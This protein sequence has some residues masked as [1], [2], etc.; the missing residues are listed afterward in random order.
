MI[1]RIGAAPKRIGCSSALAARFPV[2]KP[3][4]V[5]GTGWEP[6]VLANWVVRAEN[7]LGQQGQWAPLTRPMY[8]ALKLW[9]RGGEYPSPIL[10]A[11]FLRT[12]ALMAEAVRA[13]R[14]T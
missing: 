10:R 5:N 14:A 9:N 7:T 11:Q 1:G 3:G 8:D 12:Q 4:T 6:K 2:R 13:K